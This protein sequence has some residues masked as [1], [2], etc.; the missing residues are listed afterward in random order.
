MKKIRYGIIG[1]GNFAERAI[2]PA[3]RS[4]QN[5]ELVAIQKRNLE[6][7]KNKAVEHSIPFYFDS[8]EALVNSKEVD[9]V[10]IVSANS[11][12]HRETLLAA[13]A[14]KHV[15]V[16]KPMAINFLQ[17]KEMIEV[18]ELN[19]VKFMTG[20]MLRFSPLLRRMKEIVDS[21]LIGKISFA[22]S[23]FVYDA[24][25]SQRKW[26]LDKKNA[27]GGPLFDIGIHCLDSMRF[28]L[29]DDNVVKVN[30]LMNPQ[31]TET[32]VEKT[33]LLTFQFSKGTIGSVY[34]SYETSYRQS[35]IEFFGTKGSISAFYFTPSNTPTTLE[36]KMGKDGLVDTVNHEEISV[37]NLYELEISHFSDCILND[38]NPLVDSKSSLH[39]QHILE[40]AIN[41]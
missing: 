29:N 15:I 8:V 5:S 37:P 39:N 11:Q 28:V 25:L 30:N 33:S 3:I 23:H 36:I 21:G 16:E 12:H 35:F 4:V 9:A 20:H 18:C 22:Q 19:N 17:A 2:M 34:T 26:V 40:L 31:H 41:T 24:Q 13:R 32:G 1:F 10:F 38:T 14:K 6:N 7:A 27:G